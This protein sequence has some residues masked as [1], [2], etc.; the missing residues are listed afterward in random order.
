MASPAPPTSKDEWRSQFR[1]YRRSLDATAYAARSNLIA[2][3]SLGLPEVAEAK[4]VHCYWP[5]SDRG[6]IDTRPFIAALRSQHTDVVLP[7]VTSYDP[8]RPTLEHRRY[9]GPEA[10]E[11]NRWGI[12]EPVGTE[13]VSP[14]SLDV[15]IVPALGADRTG[16]RL[17]HGSGYYD[18]FLESVP[19]PR[20]ALIYEDCMV[21]S[22][23]N[24]PHDVPMTTLVTERR[25]IRVDDGS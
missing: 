11:P 5:L 16:H 23:P 13:V 24:A 2:H 4:R 7:V 10:L 22:L 9:T 12:C 15:V 3:R 21:E 1:A 8:A 6:E 20:I 18:A 25:V 14:D 19:C 17:G